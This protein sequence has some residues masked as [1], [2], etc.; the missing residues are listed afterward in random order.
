MRT[1]PPGAYFSLLLPCI[2]AG[3]RKR[4]A[5]LVEL[6]REHKKKETVSHQWLLDCTVIVTET[7]TESGR[8]AIEFP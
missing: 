3:R 8:F 4:K 2:A 5:T 1:P 7:G 6:C